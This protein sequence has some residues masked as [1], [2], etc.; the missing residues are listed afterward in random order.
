M[1]EN[2]F[3]FQGEDFMS[4][5]VARISITRDLLVVSNGR[6]CMWAYR[7][8]VSGIRTRVIAGLSE[9]GAVALAGV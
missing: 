3:G 5:C 1:K 7:G 6:C 4:V 2:K 9:T 8:T